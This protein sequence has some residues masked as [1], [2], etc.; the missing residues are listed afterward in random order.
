MDPQTVASICSR[1]LAALDLP[2]ENDDDSLEIETVLFCL[3][4]ET[5]EGSALEAA[6]DR[7]YETVASACPETAADLPGS[8]L[9]AAQW[10]AKAPALAAATQAAAAACYARS[11]T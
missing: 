8:L 11:S 4:R 2:V 7:A 5:E 6:L 9:D 10:R 1:A 3:I